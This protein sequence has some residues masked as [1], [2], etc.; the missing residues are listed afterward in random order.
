MSKITQLFF[1]NKYQLAIDE[2][3]LE[4]KQ[5][6][7]NYLLHMQGL[8]LRALGRISDSLFSFQQALDFDKFNYKTHIETLKALLL[9]ADYPLCLESV[10]MSIAFFESQ[11][12]KSQLWYLYQI[13][14]FCMLRMGTPVESLDPLFRAYELNPNFQTKFTIGRVQAQLEQYPDAIETLSDILQFAPAHVDVLLDLAN[15]YFSQNDFDS[16]FDCFSRATIASQRTHQNRPEPYFGVAFLLQEEEPKAALEK[17]QQAGACYSNFNDAHSWANLA[18]LFVELKKLPV[19]LTCARRAFSLSQDSQ[20]RQTLGQ[21][22][23]IMKDYVR[24]FHILSYFA[25]SS[26]PEPKW[27]LGIT[28]YELGEEKIAF[29]QLEKAAEVIFGAGVCGLRY[30]IKSNDIDRAKRFVK[31]IKG[32]DCEDKEE[33]RVAKILI[34]L[35]KEKLKGEEEDGGDIEGGV[36]AED[37]QNQQE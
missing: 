14:G 32:C 35:L 5:G 6:A 3:D 27:L 10:E 36:Q 7:N 13:R 22:Y 17:Y 31:L 37:E 16:A 9:T 20:I 34:Q 1:S 33:K 29:S 28:A 25:S 4:L 8:C 21:I 18:A 24:A 19:S 15:L 23:I 12:L 2:I 26:E 30:S 11:N